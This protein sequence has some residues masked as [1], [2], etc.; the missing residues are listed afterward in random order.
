MR[1]RTLASLVAPLLLIVGGCTVNPVTG[2]RELG[3]VSTDREIE[4]GEQQYVPAQQMQGGPYMVDPGLNRYVSRVGQ[5]L[6]EVSDRP[7]LPYEF[8]VINDG[9]PNAWA[10]PGGKIAIHRGLLVEL[11]NE[12]ELA[13]VLGHEIVHSAARHGAQSMERGM[14]M[15]TG[16]A[17][18]S[19]TAADQDY[20][21]LVVGGAGAAAGLLNQSYSREAE[22]EADRFGTRY[23]A[24]A[25]YDPQAAVTLQE[26]FVALSEGRDRGF[27]EGLFASHPPSEERVENNRELVRKLDAEGRLDGEAYQRQVA[28]LEDDADAYEAYGE[29]RR[30]LSEGDLDEAWRK[31]GTAIEAQPREALFHG[32]RGDVRY[33]QERWREAVSHYDAALARNERY[34]RFHLQRGLTH[35]RLDAPDRARRDL[36]ASN[37]LLPTA[38]AHSTLG[39]IALDQDR[40][41]DA[42]AHYRVAAGSDSPAGEHARKM[43][44]RLGASR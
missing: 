40:R 11:E 26:K 15:Q 10:L 33:R 35:H 42:I 30:A 25:G 36:E 18:L 8:T 43:L 2:E 24:R 32:L 20:R 17:A 28:T 19:I 5:S 31:A 12:A 41:E 7:E 21:N 37:E 44:E 22:R 13:A 9:T 23:M 34:F 3:F 4:I 6:A 27:V 1:N 16:L 29:G 39:D 38:S 14:I